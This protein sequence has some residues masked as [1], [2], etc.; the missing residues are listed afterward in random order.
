MSKTKYKNW[1][2]KTA[3]KNKKISS[4]F[5]TQKAAAAVHEALQRG[6]PHQHSSLL[7]V[8]VLL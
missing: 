7:L 6:S 3:Q 8:R 4:C 2:G 5:E 1:F